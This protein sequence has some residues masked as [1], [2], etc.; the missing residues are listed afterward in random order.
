MSVYARCC[1]YLE[2]HA[3]DTRGARCRGVIGRWGTPGTAT[4]ATSPV[5]HVVCCDR[6][7]IVHTSSDTLFTNPHILAIV[8]GSMPRSAM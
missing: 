6:F 8:N 5:P 1:R 2:M 4:Y 7:T 3:L